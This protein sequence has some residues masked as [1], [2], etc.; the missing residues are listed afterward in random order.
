VPPSAI[1]AETCNCACTC[2][3]CSTHS[4]PRTPHANPHHAQALGEEAEAN[5]L[6]A[7]APCCRIHGPMPLFAHTSEPRRCPP[8]P[9]SQAPCS[10]SREA[11]PCQED[12]RMHLRVPPSPRSCP[13]SQAPLQAHRSHQKAAA[14]REAVAAEEAAEPSL[15]APLLALC[16]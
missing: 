7:V 11:R 6:V 15:A 2:H 16:L 10:H 8:S 4:L 3:V 12:Q 9:L 14:A 5:P 13:S 1:S